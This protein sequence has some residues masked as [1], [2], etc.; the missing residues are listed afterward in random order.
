MAATLA[1]ALTIWATA[2]GALWLHALLGIPGDYLGQGYPQHPGLK[3]SPASLAFD[4]CLATLP[5]AALAAVA[6]LLR[7]R[8]LALPP[9]A[10]PWLF[11][12]ALLIG[13]FVSDFGTTW[14]ATEPLTAL[15]LSPVH[16]P[17]AL[18]TVLGVAW[19]ALRPRHP[20]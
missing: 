8:L 11:A 1:A 4:A 15:F 17:A 5:L 7:L 2:A 6:R 12:A 18:A 9:M 16:T 19:L 3:V 13:P 14:A 10:G 20:V